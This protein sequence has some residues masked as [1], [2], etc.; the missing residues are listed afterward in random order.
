MARSRGSG[1]RGRQQGAQGAGAAGGLSDAKLAARTGRSAAA[2]YEILDAEG[3]V[4][5]SHEQIVDLLV[6]VYEAPEWGARAVAVRYQHDHGILLPGEQPDGTFEVS[7]SRSLRGSQPA[8]L[9]LAI[10]SVNAAVKQEPTE[11]HRLPER[12]LARWE[13]DGGDVLE[14]RVGAPAASA[15]GSPCAVSLVESRIRL[16]ELVP[17]VRS[18]LEKVVR[19]VAAGA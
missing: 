11:V 13:L 3:A 17:G 14:A 10:A 4:R 15:P 2:W 19:A 16:P 12:S 9:D 18:R 8:L 1:A 5:L 7:V 6:E